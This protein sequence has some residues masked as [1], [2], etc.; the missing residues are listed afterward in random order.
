MHP[1]DTV[2][3]NLTIEYE[4]SMLKKEL[5]PEV[6]KK[7]IIK[8]VDGDL[9]LENIGEKRRVNYYQRLRDVD[10]W[11]SDNFTNPSKEDV[12]KILLQLNDGYSDWTKATYLKMLK[13]IYR[14]TLPR[15]RFETLFEDVKIKHPK[16]KIQQSDLVTPEEVKALIDT[17]NNARDRAIFSTLYD[18]GCR[19]RQLFLMKVTVQSLL[20]HLKAKQAQ[21]KLE[22]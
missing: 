19:I 5:F 16:Q 9:L 17:A 4:R 6:A 8:F 7:A 22:F 2:F 13:K 3:S 12:K 18:S 20:S 11:V 15:K 14:K 21:D 1:Y 10:R